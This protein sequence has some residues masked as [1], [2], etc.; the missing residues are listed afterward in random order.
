MQAQLQK[1][2]I[3]ENNNFQSDLINSYAWDTAI[4]YIHTFSGDVDY[5]KQSGMNTIATL[6]QTGTSI[7]STD[8][9]LDKRCNI[10]DMAGSAYEWTTETCTYTGNPC[11]ARGG[12]YN[13]ESHN[14]A[15]REYNTTEYTNMNLSFR[16]ILYL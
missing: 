12:R 15:G 14:T 1:I 16:S 5:S 3:N 9:E 13:H 7:L 8:N 11:S 2:Y 6:Q 4:M 10:Y